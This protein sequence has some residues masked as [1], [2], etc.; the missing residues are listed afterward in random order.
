MLAS[1]I[2]TKFDIP[3]AN[4][5]GAGYIRFV[6]DA[7]QIGIQAGAASKTDGF[8][9]LTFVATTAGGTPPF[10]QDMNG[11]LNQITLWSQWQGAGGL[12]FYDSVF[13]AAIGGY[14]KGAL[15][16]S[17]TAGG[18]WLSIADNNLTDPDTGGGGWVSFIGGVPFYEGTDSGTADA[19]VFDP[20]SIMPSAWVAGQ[21]YF[22][23]K[24]AAANAT[25]TP[26]FNNGVSAKTIT[27]RIGAAL[28]A[29]DLPANAELMLYFDGTHVRNM[30]VVAADFSGQL[31][32]AKLTTP[33]LGFHANGASTNYAN[34]LTLVSNL[35]TIAAN[36]LPGTSESGGIFEIG[37]T[38]YYQVTANLLTLMPNY[39]G[40]PYGYAIS[41]SICTSGGS[42]TASIAAETV[43]VGSG[44]LNSGQ[45]G[46]AS[47]IAHLAAGSYLAAFLNH[48]L[49]STINSIIISL[50]IEFLGT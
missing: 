13:S 34:G 18:I 21:I 6:P 28:A 50:D 37:T 49:G 31:N 47:G 5:A 43:F 33:Y 16:A 27:S 17:V 22:V 48:N 24:G 38:G 42:P 11:I 26:T 4:A 30:G 15:L 25:T 32:A 14:P 8:P 19:L 36:N 7:S 45:A 1:S 12:V 40:T 3:F 41:V 44:S 9:P 20:L 2:P 23:T 29:G 10:G 39:S 46:G 35:G